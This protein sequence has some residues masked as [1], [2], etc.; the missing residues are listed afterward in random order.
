MYDKVKADRAVNFIQRLKHTKGDYYG[1][2]FLLEAWQEKIIRDIFGTVLP[3]GRRQYRT[4]YIEEPRKNGKSALGAAI[5]NK[6]LYADD[7]M[8]AEVYSA[9]AEREQAAIVFN[10]AS[11]MVR[12]SPG[13]M[14][15]SKIIESTK[16]IVYPDNASFY[17][18]LSAEHATKHGFNAHGVIFD[19][20][21]AQPNRK[22]WDVL[23]TSGG[24]RSQPLVVALTTAGY[25]RN[26]ICWEQHQYALDILSGKKVNPSFYAVIFA[27]EQDDD[28]TDEKIWH[29]ANPALGTF[30]SIEEM[31]NE[32]I[33]AKD[34]PAYQNTFRRLYLNQWTSQ[35]DRWLDMSAWDA[36]N[37]VVNAEDLEGEDC[38]GGLDLA[39]TID[40]AAFVLD[41]PDGDGGHDVLP[42]FFVPEEMV[43][44][45]EL[46]DGV[47]YA[48]WIEQGFVQA[49]PGNVIDYRY[50]RNKIN[51]LG[52]IY[53]IREIA[54]DRWGATEIIQ[55][56]GD[57][58]FE[59]IMFGQGFK[60]MANPTKELLRITKGKK[61]RHGGNPVM[62]W[63]ADNMVVKQDPAGEV[64]PDKSKSSD[65]I[66]GMV[67]L[68]MGLDRA[69]KHEGGTIYDE[70]GIV[71]I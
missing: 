62:R 30:R 20:L 54:F 11:E 17:R 8:G 71:T 3:D 12:Q 36:C 57:D 60:S 25:D 5:A 21:H 27:A 2:P 66:D 64:K 53:H 16:R 37:T 14:K 49:T 28:W 23:T 52:E 9:A 48:L 44:Q 4:V 39:S 65:K 34:I 22:L 40:I 50:I 59:V 24:T 47:P 15:R 51:E 45:K 38:Y 18:V 1:L 55:S 13:L 33:K 31:R 67:A 46:R 26:S 68:I 6:L 70:R 61:L 7:E 10:V 63:M 35:E 42:F 41:F 69:L 43:E 32:F 56:L 19:E 29:K 58:G